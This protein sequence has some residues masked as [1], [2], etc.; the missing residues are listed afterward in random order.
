MTIGLVLQWRDRD[1][2]PNDPEFLASLEFL[3]AHVDVIDIEHA[4]ALQ[5]LGIGFAEIGDPVVVDAADLGQEFAVRNAVPEEALA[6]LQARPPDA[7][8]FILFDHRMRIIAALADVFPDPEEVD[9]RRVLEAL[10]GL[11]DRPQGPDL[12]REA[13]LDRNSRRRTGDWMG[14]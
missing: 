13:L 8:L 7:V 2:G 12:P 5:A 4:D 14:L 6:R 9:L 1:E 3:T 10:P 11:H